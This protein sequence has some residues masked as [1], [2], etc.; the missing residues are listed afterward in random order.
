M[1]NQIKRYKV[2]SPLLKDYIKFF[3]EL[4][5]DHAQ[6][7]H[8]LLPQR[9]INIRINLSDTPH[10]ILQ[11]NQERI[12][13]DVYFLGLQSQ[14]TD[15]YL[16]FNGKVNVMG[17]CF[18]PDGLYPFLKT[19]LSE[20]RNLILGADEIGFKTV[21]KISNKLKETNKTID[22]LI[23]LENELIS[24]LDDS[25]KPPDNFRLIFKSFRQDNSLSITEFCR[26]N[27]I[28][29]RQMER[30]YN[31]YVG[32]S[33]SSYN[34]LNRFHGSLNQLLNSGYSKL[35]DLAYVNEYFDQT[36]FIKEFKRFT[37]ETP[38]NFV[39][40]K[41]SILQIGKLT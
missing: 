9:N 20:F 8:K 7:N 13:E 27:N 19:P 23:I 24:L 36:H 37:G 15:A 39:N 40:Q 6:L 41:N 2:Q 17:I 18:Q 26:Q 4:R 32:L 5:I 12:L 14:F 1:Q 11:N 35:S 38:K 28:G 21:M 10:Y 16:K 25:F 29:L 22:R 3:W 33:A 31:R 30:R 34:T